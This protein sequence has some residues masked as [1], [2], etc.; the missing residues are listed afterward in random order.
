VKAKKESDKDAGDFKTL[1]EE[2]FNERWSLGD[3][4]NENQHPK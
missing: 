3:G 2:S 1:I 4:V